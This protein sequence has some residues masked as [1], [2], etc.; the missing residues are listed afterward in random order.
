MAV[1]M[2]IGI[3]VHGVLSNYFGTE[4]MQDYSKLLS[5]FNISLWVAFFVSLLLAFRDKQFKKIHYEQT[6]NRFGM[7]TWVAG[8]SICSILIC[9]NFPEWLLFVKFTTCL[10]VVLWLIYI[11]ICIVSFIDIFKLK[12]RENVHGILLL[13]TVSTQSLVLLL[14]T[15]FKGEVPLIITIT[16]ITLGICFYFICASLIISRYVR[17][18]SNIQLEIEWKNTNC[19]L[20]GA[21]SITGLACI[22]SNVTTQITITSIWIIAA[23]VFF[24]VEL[25]EIYR[26]I[27]RV[28]RFG[29]TSGIFVYDVTQWSRIFTFAMFYAFTFKGFSTK[30]GFLSHA[31]SIIID[32]GIWVILLL[33]LV[34]FIL[35]IKATITNYRINHTKVSGITG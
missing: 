31:Q 34:E 27:R 13:T 25:V 16:L 15:V 21:V 26:L 1:V 7:G 14:N 20:H 17:G 5:I 33:L 12:L 6:I 28:K 30:E 2:A 29:V 11:Y 24:L 10:N 18:F 9:N 8:T 35:G 4:N 3:I 23:S 22:L 32:A 19:I